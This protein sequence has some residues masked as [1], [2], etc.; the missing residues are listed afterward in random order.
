MRKGKVCTQHLACHPQQTF[1]TG[2]LGSS[3]YGLWNS[4]QSS[5]PTTLNQTLLPLESPR[6]KNNTAIFLFLAIFHHQPHTLYRRCQMFQ[7]K[8]LQW[9]SWEGSL[10]ANVIAS[11]H[12]NP[13]LKPSMKSWLW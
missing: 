4:S 5:F 11:K 12:E 6:K 10:V 9:R 7:Y 1:P 13:S 8:N 3:C 2:S